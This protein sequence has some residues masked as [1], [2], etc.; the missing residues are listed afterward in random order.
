MVSNICATSR[1]F[2][3]PVEPRARAW[4]EGRASEATRHALEADAAAQLAPVRG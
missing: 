4:A 1:R 2:A 3:E